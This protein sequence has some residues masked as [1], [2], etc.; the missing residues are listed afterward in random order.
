MFL[1]H[2]PS[3]FPARVLPGI[4][5]RRSPDFPLRSREAT[6]RPTEQTQYIACRWPALDGNRALPYYSASRSYH[7][8]RVS[9]VNG[10]RAPIVLVGVAAAAGITIALLVTSRG[11]RPPLHVLL[12]DDPPAT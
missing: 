2:F 8:V 9:M 4:L 6:A 11:S 1:W 3:G 12:I 5:A 7:G 10:R